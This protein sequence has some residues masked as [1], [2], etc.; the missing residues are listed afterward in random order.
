MRGLKPD[1]AFWCP[2]TGRYWNGGFSSSGRKIFLFITGKMK[3]W[4]GL[5][6]QEHW[7]Y[8][9]CTFKVVFGTC[10]GRIRNNIAPWVPAYLS[11]CLCRSLMCDPIFF[12]CMHFSD[13]LNCLYSSI[14]KRQSFDSFNTSL[15]YISSE[16]LQK[17]MIKDTQWLLC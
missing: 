3:R 14:V 11:L 17:T 1:M 15:K 7:W 4:K 10:T 2:E 9:K 8:C 13:W 16:K 5:K 6:W 12:C